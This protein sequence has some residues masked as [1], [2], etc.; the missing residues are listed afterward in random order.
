LRRLVVQEGG[1]FD[2]RKLVPPRPCPILPN[3]K[4][5]G[6]E[7]SRSFL[8]QSAMCPLKLDFYSSEREGEPL[9][10]YSVIFKSGDDVRQDQLVLQIITL[11]DYLLK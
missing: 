6:I 4:F 3:L 1:P 9:K 10:P 5:H 8:F 2:M 7:P 11:M